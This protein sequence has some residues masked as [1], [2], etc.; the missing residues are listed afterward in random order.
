MDDIKEANGLWYCP[1]VPLEIKIRIFSVMLAKVIEGEDYADDIL[2]T[3]NNISK[4][5]FN[6]K[7]EKMTNFEDFQSILDFLKQSDN[8]EIT[9]T[10]FEKYSSN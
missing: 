10:N 1:I 2:K 8:K 9:E 5:I 4:F 3:A 6:A 7:N